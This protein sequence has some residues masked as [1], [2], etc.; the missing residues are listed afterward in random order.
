MAQD[1]FTQVFKI[2][3]EVQDPDFSKISKKAAQ[4]LEKSFQGVK[5]S[6]KSWGLCRRHLPRQL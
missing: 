5:P 4:A 2:A 1:A 3:L 6:L